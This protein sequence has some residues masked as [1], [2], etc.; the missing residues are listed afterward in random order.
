MQIDLADRVAL[1]TGGGRGIGAAT[2]RLLAE[3]GARVVVAARS[4][5]EI[6]AV[7]AEIRRSGATAE[8]EPCDVADSAAIA[9]LRAA[10]EARFGAVDILV[11]NAG[12]ASSAARARVRPTSACLVEA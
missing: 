5:D 10:V 1:V 12:I 11:S 3:A 6:E 7:A 9:R 4:V 8:A 2:A